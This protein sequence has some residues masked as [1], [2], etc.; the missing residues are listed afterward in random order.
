MPP[1]VVGV[2]ASADAAARARAD[3][4]RR[5]VALERI[6][7]SAHL[8]EDGIAAE[9]PGQS[10]SNQPGQPRTD[11]P[12][13]SDADVVRT[14]ACALTVQPESAAEM[15]LARGVLLGEGARLQPGAAAST[16]LG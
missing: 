1:S 6:T 10:Y 12:E 9:A 5:G 2:F 3:L 16:P 11:F 13:G 14:G 4:V 8:T 15:E 7:M